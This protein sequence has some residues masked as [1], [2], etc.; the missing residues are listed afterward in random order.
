MSKKIGLPRISQQHDHSEL[1]AK[2]IFHH[3]KKCEMSPSYVILTK[4]NKKIAPCSKV[5]LK[6]TEYEKASIVQKVRIKR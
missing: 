4:Q 3:E 2:G 6:Y 1:A 5:F